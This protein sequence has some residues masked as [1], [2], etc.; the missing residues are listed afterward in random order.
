MPGENMP[1]RSQRSF[2]ASSS[3]AAVGLDEPFVRRPYTLRR[4]G[5]V[6]VVEAEAW[7]TTSCG[8]G[9]TQAPDFS[10]GVSDSLYYFSENLSAQ[11]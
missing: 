8:G 7:A 10:H 6:S 9:Q 4:L 5:D 11:R 1:G 2:L 3:S